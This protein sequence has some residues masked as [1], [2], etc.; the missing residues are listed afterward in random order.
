MSAGSSAD[1]SPI[2]RAKRLAQQLHRPVYIKGE[3]VTTTRP[4][5]GGLTVWPNGSVSMGTAN[6]QQT[7][8]EVERRHSQPAA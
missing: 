7:A 1:R 6:T 4:R 3:D 2:V 5:G 8:R